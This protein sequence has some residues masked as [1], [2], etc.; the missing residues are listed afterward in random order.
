M[1]EPATAP[2]EKTNVEHV[3]NKKGASRLIQGLV[4]TDAGDRQHADL[5]A[6]WLDNYRG[7]WRSISEEESTRV[8][9]KIDWHVMPM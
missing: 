8:R 1:P 3:E 5:A 7:E 2:V 9:W 4:S 6:Q